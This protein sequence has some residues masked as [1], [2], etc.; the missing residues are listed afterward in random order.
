MTF[1]VPLKWLQ[2]WCNIFSYVKDN[3]G[4][5]KE[6]KT[7][8]IHFFYPIEA[9]NNDFNLFK[10]KQ[11]LFLEGRFS[12]NENWSKSII[13]PW[14]IIAKWYLGIKPWTIFH[15]F[16]FKNCKF[17]MNQNKMTNSLISVINVDDTGSVRVI[18]SLKFQS[19][20]A[21]WKYHVTV[22]V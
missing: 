7:Y 8:I 3:T 5:T 1:E 2:I 22:T 18:W 15:Y 20:I 19:H 14:Q 13:Y 11:F 6:K 16:S 10:G 17:P 4:R 21:A 12:G 9:F